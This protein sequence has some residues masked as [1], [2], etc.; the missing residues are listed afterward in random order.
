VLD[1]VDE[2]V[3]ETLAI[4]RLHDLVVGLLLH[5]HRLRSDRGE[6]A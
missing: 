2:T 3:D 1:L 5:F 6:T 4:D